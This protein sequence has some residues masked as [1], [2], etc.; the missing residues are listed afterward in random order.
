MF[1]NCPM[2]VRR[3]VAFFCAHTSQST[4]LSPSMSS[5]IIISA[6]ESSILSLPRI[7][8]SIFKKDSN[9][10]LGGCVG[11]RIG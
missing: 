10:E 5:P 7:M 11:E 4:L 3:M 2:H 8:S 9:R 1:G 6:R